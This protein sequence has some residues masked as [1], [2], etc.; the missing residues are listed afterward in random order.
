VE[1]LL[2]SHD[3][4]CLQ[5]HWLWGFEKQEM[6]EMLPNYGMHVKTV[7]EEM[8]MVEHTH[9]VTGDGGV[10]TVWSE[11]IDSIMVP[12]QE[13][14]NSRVMVTECSLATSICL[15][16]CYLPSGNSKQAVSNFSEDVDVLNELIQKYK[17][18]HQILMVGDFNADHYHRKSIKEIHLKQL[19]DGNSLK[20]LGEGIQDEPSYINPH[21]QHRSRIDHMFMGAITPDIEGENIH[22]IIDEDELNSSYHLPISLEIKH[23]SGMK[24]S[25]KRGRSV[26]CSLG[27]K[28]TKRSTRQ[29]WKNS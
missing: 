9:R 17:A 1:E 12:V 28:W 23:S 13:E 24:K 29:Q 8:D 21:L 10:A 19:I 15:I 25:T 18:T 7:D 11:H 22:L 4:I 16:N 26:L 2:K 20:D 3:I 6:K 14:G 27:R 5:E